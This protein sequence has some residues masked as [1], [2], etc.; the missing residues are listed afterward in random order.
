MKY[1]DFPNPDGFI[2]QAKKLKIKEIKLVGETE[3]ISAKE[4]PITIFRMVATATKNDLDY[5]L[6]Y[7]EKIGSDVSLWNEKMNELSQKTRDRIKHF[8]NVL[9]DNG[10]EVQEAIWNW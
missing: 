9:E 10:F 6:R 2:K 1:L 3:Q 7:K 5:I 8:T 4:V